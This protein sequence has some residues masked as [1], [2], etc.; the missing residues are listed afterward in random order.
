MCVCSFHSFGKQL[1]GRR[2]C[3]CITLE[4]SEMIVVSRNTVCPALA[5]SLPKPPPF[6][7]SYRSHLRPFDIIPVFC[8]FCHLYLMSALPF[9]PRS[10]LFIILFFPLSFISLPL[11]SCLPH[12]CASPLCPPPLPPICPSSDSNSDELHWQDALPNCSPLKSRN[13]RHIRKS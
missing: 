9:Y 8:F 5:L 4:P 13:Y 6:L 11:P 10:I 7:S 2:G 12:L 1:G 3:E